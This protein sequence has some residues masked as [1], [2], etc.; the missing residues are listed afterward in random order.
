MSRAREFAPIVVL[1]DGRALVTA[2]DATG[3]AVEVY[4]AETG[5]FST[6]GSLNEARRF[7]AAARLHTGGVL[8]AGGSHD[9]T[10]L[11]SA[12]VY[13]VLSGAFVPTG[14]MAVARMGHTLTPLQDG[15]VLVLG[16][17][18][19]SG[20][21]GRAELFDAPTATFL[22]GATMKVPRH[23]PA[24]LLADGSVLVA[25][26]ETGDGTYT[27]SA[28]R[29]DAGADAFTT[30]GSLAIARHGHDAALLPDGRV[31]IT[32]G[33]DNSQTPVA[34]SEIYDPVA[35]TFQAAG[36]LAIP[37]AFH[38]SAPI[39]DG[40]VLIFGG[41]DLAGA[42]GSAEIYDPATG[43]FDAVPGLIEPRS[44]PSAVSLGDGRVL[45]TGGRGV[46]G[47]L[48]S[49][50]ELHDGLAPPRRPT[51]TTVSSSANPAVYGQTVTY[52]AHVEGSGES[53][54]AKVDFLDGGSLLLGTAL[55]D[56][57]GAAVLT[58]AATPAGARSI[59]AAYR[60]SATSAGS[61]SQ[62]MTQS[63]AKTPT[64][65]SLSISPL[66]RAY[67][68][69]AVFEATVSGAYGGQPA[70]GVIF[71]VGSQRMHDEPIPFEHKGGGVWKAS[72]TTPLLETSPAGQLKPNG[73]TKIVT[74]TVSGA[75]PNYSVA[76]PTAKPLLITKEDARPSYDGAREVSTASR[77][78]GRATIPLRATIRDIAATSEANGDK[79]AGNIGLAQV[80]FVDRATNMPIATVTV[81]GDSEDSSRGVARYDWAVDIGNSRSK[82]YRVGMVV[83]NYYMRNSTAEDA[84]IVVSRP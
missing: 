49:T 30:T 65:S 8:V 21:E 13:D 11:A 35:G 51:T 27:A 55:V 10:L 9:S 79:S 64:K 4:D 17:H 71:H 53:A 66:S 60:G 23:S 54:G 75:S 12:E 61:T 20:P 6:T 1:E 16:G 67:S 46:N 3:A 56:S 84:T 59:S 50:S 80:T 68:D 34:E 78:S 25:G 40:K 14:S 47:E 69:L 43:T 39:A 58:T 37:R 74:A 5:R 76:N 45:I 22:P 19:G 2:N 24:V 15:R 62:P 63:V 31:L 38:R 32:G 82:S 48:L 33:I 26:G 73:M 77:S 42:L 81:S 52:T 29:Y 44:A 36:R 7:A 28:E 72:L 83:G 41:R 57:A 70:D 18:N